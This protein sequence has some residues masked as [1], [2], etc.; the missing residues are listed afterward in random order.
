MAKLRLNAAR[1]PFYDSGPLNAVVAAS[2]L[3]LAIA[4]FINITVFLGSWARE[5]QMS[6]QKAEDEGLASETQ[7]ATSALEKRMTPRMSLE[8]HKVADNVAGIIERR[9]LSWSRLFDEL[10]RVLPA[11]VRILSINPDFQGGEVSLVMECIAQSNGQ[12]LEFFRALQERPFRDAHIVAEMFD[13]RT[14]RFGIRCSYQPEGVGES[15]RRAAAIV[16]GS[17]RVAKLGESR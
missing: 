1:R 8:L 13:Q 15:G 10:A 5:R 14:I 17:S 2:A 12:K 3:L 9:R 4:T 7:R 11:D 16:G 6:W